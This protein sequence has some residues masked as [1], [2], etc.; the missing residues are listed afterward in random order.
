[1]IKHLKAY[2][3][4]KIIPGLISFFSI[5]LFARIF[6]IEEYGNYSYLFSVTTLLFVVLFAWIRL[7]SFRFYNI[8]SD[9]RGKNS[10]LNYVFSLNICL[11]ILTF[12]IIFI[13]SKEIMKSF[14]PFIFLAAFTSISSIFLEQVYSLNRAELKSKEFRMYSIIEPIVKLIIILILFYFIGLKESS[15]FVGSIISTLIIFGFYLFK[16]F[17]EE[18][19]KLKL[20]NPIKEKEITTD[21]LKYGLPLTLS[22]LFSII[23]A[24]SD[25]IL[26]KFYLDEGSVA[27]YSMSYDLSSFVVVNIFMIL[28]FTFL[29]VI[30]KLVDSG[31]ATEAKSKINNYFWLIIFTLIPVV[32]FL[33]TF[34][35]EITK[36]VLGEKYNTNI[37]IKIIQFMGIGAFLSGIKSFFYDFSFQVGKKTYLQIIPIAISAVLNVLLNIWWLPIMGLIGAIYGTIVSI[38]VGLILSII[39]GKK[40]FRLSVEYKKVFIIILQLTIFTI[41]LIVIPKFYKGIHT[42]IFELTVFVILYCIYVL[43]NIG[44]LK[45]VLK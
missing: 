5:M 33:L 38:I 36:Y 2:A 41:F 14:H 16:L 7:S 35:P 27:M 3:P 21:F 10:Y 19:I 34:S 11:A 30:L 23:L 12:T 42:L 9:K 18:R 44:N 24:T 13:F 25:R 39:L 32:V 8:Y 28:N 15:I 26:I 43:I 31:K 20:I 4:A 1:M 29:P 40:A 45:R 17:K 22:F 37:N 6:T